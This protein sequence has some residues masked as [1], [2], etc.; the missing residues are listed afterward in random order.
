MNEGRIKP[1]QKVVE[2][3]W[4]VSSHEEAITCTDGTL[5]NVYDEDEHFQHSLVYEDIEDGPPVDVKEDDIQLSNHALYEL[6]S[7]P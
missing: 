4:P 6:L 2:I 7:I 3:P 5:E 1:R